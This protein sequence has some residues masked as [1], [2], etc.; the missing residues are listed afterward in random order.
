MMKI[1][2]VLALIGG[3]L[4]MGGIFSPWL[5]TISGW[6]IIKGEW[7]SQIPS[8]LNQII[9]LEVILVLIGGTAIVASA[10]GIL[11]RG[12][13][14]FFTAVLFIGS[15]LSLLP[16]MSSEVYSD[17]GFTMAWCGAFLGLIS[18]LAFVQCL[19]GGKEE[20]YELRRHRPPYAFFYY[21]IMIGLLSLSL[22]MIFFGARIFGIN[23]ILSLSSG[24][25]LLS[26]PLLIIAYF[27]KRE[28]KSSREI[29]VG[30][31][32]F[33][34]F[35]FIVFAILAGVLISVGIPILG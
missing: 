24:V 31:L 2:G 13:S 8:G 22:L 5:G 20:Y 27:S 23:Q 7:V 26:V 17:Y 14:K 6:E 32:K 11:A 18:S 3:C 28:G 4:V 30:L 25:A 12:G 19:Y 33:L 34:L 16:V 21:N 29:C 1:F 15:F 10:I 9:R 35:G